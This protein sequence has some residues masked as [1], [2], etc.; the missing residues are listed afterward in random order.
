MTTVSAGTAAA[1]RAVLGE[2]SGFAALAAFDIGGVGR[3]LAVSD[4]VAG[5]AAVLASILVDARL[6][7]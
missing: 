1:L 3:L 5:F 7:T 2:V 4:L 6:G